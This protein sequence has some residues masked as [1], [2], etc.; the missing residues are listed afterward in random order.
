VDWHSLSWKNN[1]GKL[2]P[3]L[4]F[5]TTLP[6]HHP[7]LGG[8]MSSEKI[9]LTGTAKAYVP[10]AELWVVVVGGGGTRYD[11]F[12]GDDE[13]ERSTFT[14]VSYESPKEDSGSQARSRFEAATL[15]AELEEVGR[16][17]LGGTG[18]FCCTKAMNPGI[19]SF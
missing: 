17:S 7:K 1:A 16:A 18:A 2:S 4:V 11:C 9:S 14:Y 8:R 19:L 3:A 6:N 13:S 5:I 15:R 12:G 10:M